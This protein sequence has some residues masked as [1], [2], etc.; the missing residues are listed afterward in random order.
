MTS[1]IIIR[2]SSTLK[3]IG[4]HNAM[5]QVGKN[6]DAKVFPAHLS[7][8]RACSPYFENPP[9]IY[10]VEKNNIFLLIKEPNINPTTFDLIHNYNSLYAK[11]FHD[12]C[13]KQA[14]LLL[15]SF[16]NSSKIYGGYRTNKSKYSGL[17]LFKGDCFIFSL[18][19]DEDTRNMKM[20]R[21]FYNHFDDHMNFCY[22]DVN[23]KV[24]KLTNFSPSKVEFFEIK[25][26]NRVDFHPNILRFYGI[27]KEGTE[28]WKYEIDERPDIQK[29]VSTLKT[30][31]SL[32]HCEI[33]HAK[34]IEEVDLQRNGTSSY[35]SS[36]E[37][38]DDLENLEF[39][40]DINYYIDESSSLHSRI[41]FQ[42]SISD[43]NSLINSSIEDKSSLKSRDDD[44]EN[45]E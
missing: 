19:N 18:E 10:T 15:V 22:K 35:I 12:L 36:K 13:I 29:I 7:V 31:I 33:F 40:E 20:T 28:C 38:D 30:I 45:L 6:P 21:I 42:P 44:L 11:H 24:V 27:T 4:N 17:S 16:L 39:P 1:S 26:H 23:D 3:D 5:I 37:R 43:N 2:L 32:E 14:T 8:L 41:S 25:L 34:L 9:P